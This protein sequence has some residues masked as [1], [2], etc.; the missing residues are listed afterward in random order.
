[1]QRPKNRKTCVGKI[2]T[3]DR[4]RKAQMSIKTP[5]WLISGGEREEEKKEERSEEKDE[6][7]CK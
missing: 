6:G 1:M 3:I 5:I 2:C 7:F 4:W